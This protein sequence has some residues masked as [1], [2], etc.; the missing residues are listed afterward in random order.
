VHLLLNTIIIQVSHSTLRQS[1][2]SQ[3][4][5]H[6]SKLWNGFLYKP[7]KYNSLFLQHAVPAEHQ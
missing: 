2:R 6:C 1:E 5:S 3:P 7:N 4:P